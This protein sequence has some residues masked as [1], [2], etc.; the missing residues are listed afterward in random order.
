MGRGDGEDGRQGSVA[1]TRE[2]ARAVLRHDG[3]VMYGTSLVR[4]SSGVFLV[5]GLDS[6][7]C[8]YRGE[9]TDAD[10]ALDIAETPFESWQE[11]TG[12]LS[13][14]CGWQFSDE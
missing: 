5:Y 14:A 11:Q 4:S 1:W 6:L 12:R 3:E 13:R 8:T 2:A 9:F 10:R 7:G